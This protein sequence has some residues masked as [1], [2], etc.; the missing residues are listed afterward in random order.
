MMNE[1]ALQATEE[2]GT[3]MIEKSICEMVSFH[4][5]DDDDVCHRFLSS[6]RLCI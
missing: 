2:T 5:H 1:E 4:H 3:V 6:K